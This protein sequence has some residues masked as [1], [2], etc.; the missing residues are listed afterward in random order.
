[1]PSRVPC[2]YPSIQPVPAPRSQNTGWPVGYPNIRDKLFR[3]NLL[4]C[5][6]WQ[7]WKS[8]ST[9]CSPI[10]LVVKKD[11]SIRFFVDYCKVNEVPEAARPHGLKKYISWKLSERESLSQ[12]SGERVPGDPKDG[13]LPLLLSPWLPFHPLLGSCPAAMA[14]LHEGSQ[15]PDHLMVCGVRAL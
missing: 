4:R 9:W 8:H 11:G 6:K 1:M 2:T 10:V 14:P 5:W 15:C 12:H 13:G 3:R 7:W